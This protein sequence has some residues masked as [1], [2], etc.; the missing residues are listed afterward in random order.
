[1]EL[2]KALSYA[3]ISSLSS[4]VVS[5]FLDLSKME[6]WKGQSLN[7]G[8]YRP[9]PFELNLTSL[10]P[11]LNRMGCRL[12]YPRV[13]PAESSEMPQQI[14]FVEVSETSGNIWKSG[15]YGI[16]EPH[17][18]LQATDPEKLH[19]IFVPGVAFGFKGERV[20]MGGGFYDRY[21]DQAPQ[22]LRVALAFD[23]QVFPEIEQASHDQPVHWVVTE[24]REFKSSFV[25]QWGEIRAVTKDN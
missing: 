25:Q 24:V 6:Q 15:P 7:V 5:R 23:F 21:L 20:G 10:E 1:L 22:A 13:I 8:L 14:E 2:R 18:T 11:A 9:L 12:H 3:E 16:Q 17:P 4:Q 19:V